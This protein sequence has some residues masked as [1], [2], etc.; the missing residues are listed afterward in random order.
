[1]Q[2]NQFGEFIHGVV[3]DAEET[4]SLSTGLNIAAPT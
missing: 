2:T 4:Y 3:A 1:M